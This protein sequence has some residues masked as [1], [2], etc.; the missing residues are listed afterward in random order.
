MQKDFFEFFLFAKLATDKD[1]KL[2][3]RLSS[4]D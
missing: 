3:E 2:K 4:T 1:I